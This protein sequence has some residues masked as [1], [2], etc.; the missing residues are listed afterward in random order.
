MWHLGQ[1]KV[2]CLWRCPQFRSVLI[3]RGFTVYTYTSCYVCVCVCN[4]CIFCCQIA[5]GQAGRLPL[6]PP[7]SLHT[8]MLSLQPGG[9]PLPQLQMPPL[10]AAAFSPQNYHANY[11][12]PVPNVTYAVP[13]TMTPI[14]LASSPAMQGAGLPQQQTQIH[15]FGMGTPR[16]GPG[17]GVGSTGT[18]LKQSRPNAIKIVDPAT[19]KEV[20]LQGGGS[21]GPTGGNSAPRSISPSPKIRAPQ[22]QHMTN[23]REMFKQQVHQL[24]SGQNKSNVPP[25]AMITAPP[26]GH[27]TYTPKSTLDEQTP[28]ISHNL[29]PIPPHSHAPN[30]NAPTFCPVGTPH[31]PMGAATGQIQIHPPKPPDIAPPG[32]GLLATPNIQ[33][34]PLFISSNGQHITTVPVIP[35]DHLRPSLPLNVTEGPSQPAVS[36]ATATIGSQVQLQEMAAIPVKPVLEPVQSVVVTTTSEKSVST[37][38]RQPLLPTPVEGLVATPPII[39][40]PIVPPQTHILAPPTI[41]SSVVVPE[42]GESAKSEDIVAPP[43]SLITKETVIIKEPVIQ[44]PVVDEKRVESQTV[45]TNTVEIGHVTSHV[46]T[47]D[48]KRVESQTVETNTVEIGHVTSHV[49]TVDEKRVESQTNTVEIGH[50]TSHVMT[51]DEKRVESQTNTVEIGHVTSHVMTVDEKRVESQTVET[52]TVETVP[53]SVN[54]ES[55]SD[56]T[57]LVEEKNETIVG[58]KKPTDVEERDGVLEQVEAVGREGD[59]VSMSE[60]GDDVEEKTDLKL[61]VKESVVVGDVVTSVEDECG[62]VGD[63]V[64]SVE[65]ERGEVGDV[66]TSVEDE[67]GEVGDVVTSV[68]DERGEVGD[69]VTSVEDERGEVG[70]V[71]TSVEDECGEVGDIDKQ[72][73]QVTQEA[74]VQVTSAVEDREEVE[75]VR[76][77]EGEGAREKEGERGGVGE[78]EVS[79]ELVEN[80]EHLE[81]EE[82]KIEEDTVMEAEGTEM[83]DKKTKEEEV[84]STDVKD[85]TKEDEP[86]V[87]KVTI[88]LHVIVHKPSF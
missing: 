44:K 16:G 38:H 81:I 67:R 47:V 29:I 26:T 56:V 43:T 57:S 79:K 50:V 3:E 75:G 9:Q 14:G 73:S 34:A 10:A 63:V 32:A 46:M 84:T 76:E 5:P 39:K 77:K 8:T 23:A 4:L 69:V 80:R 17:V 62:E 6:M 55:Y 12:V 48:E 28:V 87:V 83:D 18:T 27:P 60:T 41:P 51:V 37:Q 22:D 21:G 33:G 2:S 42:T 35:S 19:M 45:E 1:V 30:P 61:E 66:V 25:N 7:P 54:D 68:E 71:V 85:V 53:V 40:T 52:N 31:I 86:V 88:H 11:R 72:E 59:A 58:E 70:D 36:V 64:T 49:M 65:D 82:E 15:N 20:D 24:H 13:P 74:V 78:K